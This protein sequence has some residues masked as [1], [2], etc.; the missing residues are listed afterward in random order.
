MND[1]KEPKTFTVEIM[2]GGEIKIDPKNISPDELNG[3][4]LR[5]AMQIKT[6]LR[7]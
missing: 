1:Q 5:L 7:M 6:Q 3:V 2:E 4:I